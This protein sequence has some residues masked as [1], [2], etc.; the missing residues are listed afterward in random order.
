MMNKM[1]KDVYYNVKRPG[2]YGGVDSLSR[3]SRDVKKNTIKKWLEGEDTYTIHKPIKRKFRRRK[4]I[5]G[6][7]NHQFQADLVDLQNIKKGN[8]KTN[9]LLTCIDVFSKY[10]YVIP[11]KDKTGKSI[12]IAFKKIFKQLF[13]PP[14]Y[15]QTDAGKEFLNSIFQK[16]L[17]D[18]K[19][20]HFVTWNQATKS[21]VVEIFNRTLKSRMFR[22]FTKHSTKRY[23]DILPY[24]VKS[25][26]N[27]YHSSIK[28]A[29]IQ[30]N[31]NNQEE[32]WQRLYG[33]DYHPS[34][35]NPFPVRTRVRISK[36]KGLFEKGY[37]PN[38]TQELFTVD[39]VLYRTN[40]IT[41]KVID[42]AEDVLRGTFYK[43]ELQRVTEKEV[44]RIA[45]ILKKRRVKGVKQYLIQW[46]G[47]P[48][49][50]DS[51]VRAKDVQH[52]E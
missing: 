8:N 2:S 32:V 52:Y 31:K 4:V 10:A 7:I 26:N 46:L 22:Y 18:Q 17:K 34:D 27:T 36:A 50:F 6:G 1:L 21:S 19:V 13:R 5:T 20:K 15:L 12:T 37:L 39:K 35:P 48:R 41:Y 28:L 40:P 42:D 51:W 9:Y 44:Y 24:L 3:V 38:W 16:Y 43:E 14:Y 29:P 23:I 33:S 11:L 30:V 25:Y 47:Y 49:S 45:N